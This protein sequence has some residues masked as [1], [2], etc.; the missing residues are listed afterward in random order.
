MQ[1]D[2]ELQDPENAKQG[3]YR[4]PGDRSQEQRHTER[5][6]PVRA[7]EAHPHGM[8]IFENEDE[9]QYQHNESDDSRSPGK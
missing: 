7:K 5:K 9:Q 2:A 4:R 1:R 3:Q 6:P 8:K